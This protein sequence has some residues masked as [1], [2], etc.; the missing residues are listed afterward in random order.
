MQKEKIFFAVAI[1]SLAII[2]GISYA[3]SVAPPIATTAIIPIPSNATTGGGTTYAYNSPLTSN[4]ANVVSLIIGN[5]L[6]VNNANQLYTTGITLGANIPLFIDTNNAISLPQSSSTSN[7]FLSSTDWSTFN[8]KLSS[9]TYGVNTIDALLGAVNVIAGGNVV[10]STSGQNIIITALVPP[11][12]YGVNSLNTLVGA[13]NLIGENN[14][15]ATLSGQNVVIGIPQSSSTSNGFLSSTDWS[16]FNSVNNKANI[17]SVANALTYVNNVLSIP[18]S[19]ATSSGF[20]SSTDWSTFNSKANAFSVANALTFINNVLSIPQSSATSSGFLSSTDWSTFNSKANAF[21]VANALTFINNVLSI[22]QSSSTT[23]GFLS[24]TDWSTFN[25]KLDISTANTLYYPL[26]ANP[27]N[28]LTNAIRNINGITN[29]I[30]SIVAG[31]NIVVSTN[32]ITN[33]IIISA[34]TQSGGSG[35]GV[36]SLNGLTGTV[37]VIS[38]DSNIIVGTNG[39]NVILTNNAPFMGGNTLVI[40]QGYTAE[41][42]TAGASGGSAPYSYQWFSE[43]PGCGSFSSITGATNTVYFFN[44][45]ALTAKGTWQFLVQVTDNTPLTQNSVTTNVIVK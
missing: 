28:Y 9:Q 24:S 40:I 3:L 13:I 27:S 33:T 8:N 14:I 4:A 29:S 41:I 36:S 18:Q 25:S 7:G 34:N 1:L 43:C 15:Y 30:T 2:G 38:A 32:T 21:S 5:G 44:T 11:Q 26:N 39:Q 31:S 23:S 20:L 19:S 16:T 12:T 6:A 42:S 10:V 45:N 37:N 22:P 17:F 35:A